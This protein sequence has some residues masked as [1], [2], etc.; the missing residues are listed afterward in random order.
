[1]AK[2]SMYRKLL[3]YTGGDKKSPIFE[4]MSG[5][6]VTQAFIHCSQCGKAIYTQMGPRA[7]AWCIACTEKDGSK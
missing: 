1:M 6:L 4:P 7:D 2:M 3:G 5:A